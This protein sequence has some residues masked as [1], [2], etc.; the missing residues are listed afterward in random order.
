MGSVRRA[1]VSKKK[2]PQNNY[3]LSKTR[4][5]AETVVEYSPPF[6]SVTRMRWVKTDKTYTFNDN[7]T[8]KVCSLWNYRTKLMKGGYVRAD[9]M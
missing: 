5:V 6:N 3:T 9:V 1:V 7:A 2:S 4:L 8:V